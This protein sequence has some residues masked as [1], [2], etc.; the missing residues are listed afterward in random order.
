MNKM[1]VQNLLQKNP[2]WKIQFIIEINNYKAIVNWQNN[3]FKIIDI[4]KIISYLP[5][6]FVK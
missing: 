3:K 2:L 5:N 4:C 6:F 1:I